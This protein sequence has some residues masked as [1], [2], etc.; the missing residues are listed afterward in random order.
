MMGQVHKAIIQATLVGMLL[1]AS[2]WAQAV[3]AERY[4]LRIEAKSIEQALRALANASGKQ[5]LFP[6]DQVDDM[7]LV[8]ISGHYTLD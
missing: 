3:D 1:L 7:E 8:S 6:Y 4:P 5:L 2:A